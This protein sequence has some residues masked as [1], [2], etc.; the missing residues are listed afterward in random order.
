MESSEVFGFTSSQ[1]DLLARCASL[2][3]LVSL[4]FLVSLVSLLRFSGSPR[5][6][7]KLF[8]GSPSQ[9]AA[10]LDQPAVKHFPSEDLLRYQ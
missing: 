5:L 1:V 9:L 6:L 7:Q 4:G 10:S 8:P 2:M 3:S